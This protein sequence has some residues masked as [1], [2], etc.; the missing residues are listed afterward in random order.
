MSTTGNVVTPAPAGATIINHTGSL[1][2]RALILL[3]LAF[4]VI[5]Y[6]AY[7]EEHEDKIQM[8]ATVKAQQIVIDQQAQAAKLADQHIAD[9][10]AVLSKTVEALTQVQAHAPAS[11]VETAAEI[12]KY[13]Q[14]PGAPVV[15][16]AQAPGAPASPSPVAGSVIFAPAQAEDLRKAAVG[17]AEDAAKLSGCQKDEQDRDAKIAALQVENKALAA[18]RDAAIKAQKGGSLLTRIKRDAEH[19]GVGFVA[20][21]IAGKILLK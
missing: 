21:M 17:C 2:E 3:A 20:G 14:L 19:E 6:R 4:L 1:F 5:G 11:P 9:R 10:D 7:K 16:Q 15:V 13:L 18:Q 12:A 8:Q